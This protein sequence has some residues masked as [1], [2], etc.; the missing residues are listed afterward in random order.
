MRNNIQIEP[1]SAYL[2]FFADQRQFWLLF[3]PSGREAQADRPL[4]CVELVEVEGGLEALSG[5]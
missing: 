1:L 4:T 2:P 5:N 3:L